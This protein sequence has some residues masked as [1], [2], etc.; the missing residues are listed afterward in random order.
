MWRIISGLR[1]R[2]LFMMDVCMLAITPLLSLFLRMDAIDG[3]ATLAAP[4][5]VYTLVTVVIKI[6]TFHSLNFY[7]RYWKYASVDEIVAL[8]FGTLT[9]WAATIVVFFG[10]LRTFHLL[11]REFPS[12]IPIIDGI[13][14]MICVGG[15]RLG[16]KLVYVFGEREHSMPGSH[17]V[18]IVGAG[19]T[20]S[21]IVKELKANSKL[22]MKPVAFVDDDPA[23]QNMIIHDV[24]VMGTIANMAEVIR[25]NQIDEVIIAMP[26][27]SGKIIRPIVETCTALKIK[28]KTIPGIFGILS[29]SAVAQLRDVNIEDLLRRETITIDEQNVARFIQG[30]R[31]LVTGAG[32]S[33]G[34]ELCRQIVKYR[35]SELVM[36]GHGEN[37]IFQIANEMKTKHGV[38]AETIRYST[39][40]A[41]IRDRDRMKHV[42]ETHRPQIIFHAAAH[43]HVGLMERNIFDA[44]TNNIQGTQLLVDLCVQHGVEKFVM[45]S[46]DKAVNPVC[47]MGVTKRVAELIVCDAA[48]KHRRPFVIVRF[49]NVLGS[50]GSIIPILQNQI[51]L[52]GPMTVTHPYATRFFMTIPEAVQLVLQAGA[53]GKC[54]DTFVLD[55]GKQIRIIDLARDLIR[56]SGLEEGRDIDI[57]YTGL[58]DGEKMHEELFY[59]NEHAERSP[60]EKIFICSNGRSAL[61]S[62]RFRGLIDDLLLAVHSGN[63]KKTQACLMQLVSQY[64]VRKDGRKRRL[65]VRVSS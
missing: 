53:M 19:L 23:K 18:L 31:V 38:V 6:G 13:L 12:S 36:L 64:T 63:T 35:P 3:L 60:H 33:I 47:A 27:V 59:A 8:A 41:D 44:V 10:V 61:T 37:S 20:G 39:V 42:L 49:G 45:I 50:R 2:H 58:R 40:I 9:S 57:V 28:S 65:P 48:E 62:A 52:G 24:R 56:L 14:T 26:A 17:N 22:A 15:V 21:M 5:M 51:A 46:T 16:V 25:N 43:K 7:D 11:P 55:M 1:N 32:G 29:G 54:G 34:S 30:R 4:L